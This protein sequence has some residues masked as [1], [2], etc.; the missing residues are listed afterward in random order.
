L[1]NKGKDEARL[2]FLLEDDADVSLAR[3]G[4]VRAVASVVA[5]GL[6][7]FGVQPLEEMR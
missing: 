4:L 7:I 2:R 6:K 3:L 5:S 1:W